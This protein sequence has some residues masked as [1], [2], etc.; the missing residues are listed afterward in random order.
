MCAALKLG[1]FRARLCL[2]DDRCISRAFLAGSLTPGVAL[3][4]R[5]AHQDSL[6]PTRSSSPYLPLPLLLQLQSLCGLRGLCQVPGESQRALPGECQP[7]NQ[8]R[9]PPPHPGEGVWHGGWGGG[10]GLGG[11]VPAGATSR[12]R[13]SCQNSKAWTKMVIRNIAA[14]GKFSSDRTIKEYARD[15]W[16]VEPSD[17]KIP[18][19]NEPRE[20]AEDGTPNGTEARA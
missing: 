4:A 15:I 6:P 1:Y 14:A 17:L 5:A 3:A 13:A 20:V 12:P 11:Q 16:H 18:P 19:P 9:N 2:G 7:G 8:P 10:D